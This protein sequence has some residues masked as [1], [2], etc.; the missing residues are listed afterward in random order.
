MGAAMRCRITGTSQCSRD[1]KGWVKCISRWCDAEPKEYECGGCGRHIVQLAG[2]V[3]GTCGACTLNP[4][5]FN[6]PMMAHIID[7]GN[8][9]RPPSVH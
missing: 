6:D 7:P 3:T 5:W 8:L 9:R 1:R 2:P 4:G